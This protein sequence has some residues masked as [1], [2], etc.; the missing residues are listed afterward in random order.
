MEH[1]YSR[2]DGSQD[3]L[4]PDIDSGKLLDELSEDLLSGLGPSAALRRLLR[5]GVQ[6]LTRGLDDLALH[7]RRMR[8]NLAENLNIDGPLSR[9]NEKLE[10]ILNE[11]RGEL[12]K[13][14][15]SDHRFKESFL[16]T[17]P[18]GPGARMK[19]LMD[20]RFASEPAQL[21]FDALVEEMQQQILGSYFNSLAGSLQ[22][23][24]ADDV[25]AMKQMIADLREMIAARDEGRTYD[26]DAFMSAHGQFFPENPKNLDELLEILAR[27]MAAMSR[28]MASLSPEQHR[29]LQELTEAMMSDLDLA[30][31]MSL[32]EQ[33]M[34]SLMPNLGWDEQVPGWGENPSSLSEAVAAVEQMSDLEDLENALRGDYAGSSL[35]DVDEEKLA[36]ALGSEAVTDFRRLREIEKALEESGVFTRVKGN[37]QLTARGVR[38]LGERAL[39]KVF[40][41]LGRERPG[42]HHIRRT[43]GAGEPTG[44]MRT[45]EFGDTGPLAVQKS[46]FNAVTRTGGT[47][48]LKIKPEDLEVIEEEDR[49]RT[50]TALLLDLSFSMPLRGHWVPAKKMALALH[51]LIESKYPED[52]IYLIG[53]SDYARRLEPAD[54]TVTEIIERVYGTNMQHAFLLARRLLAQ[55]PR[56]TKQVIMVTDGEPTAHLVDTGTSSGPHA[57]F[58]WPPTETTIYKTLAEASRLAA[59]GITLNIFMLEEDPGLV[60]FMAQLAKRT[61][62]RV[63][64]AAGQDIGKFVIRDFVR[65]GR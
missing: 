3:P 60:Q 61:S 4:G 19:E 52:N 42:G 6:G 31:E 22:R 46:L 38:R 16:Q 33:E 63:F 25:A 2:W 32:L 30:F 36:S 50:A 23:I 11:E 1:N 59:A 29:Q 49:S 55:H 9:V 26:F 47:L 40:E 65:K 56:S 58:S 14:D 34:R 54:L 12:A 5:Q 13:H 57:V 7:A 44:G 62:G 28:L 64:Q 21:K 53:F 17:L 41:E 37:L 43:G 48:P 35:E 51:S 24:T 8:R 20:Y 15:D 10:E 18:P 45:W 39:V 27:R